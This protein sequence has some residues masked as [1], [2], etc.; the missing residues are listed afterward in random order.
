MRRFAVATVATAI[1]LTL[2][3][4]PAWVA[5]ADDGDSTS[6]TIPSRA[7][8]RAA[9]DAASDKAAE[10]A[11]VQAQLAVANDSLR[12]SAIRAA[13]AE[14]AFNRARWNYREARKAA[15]AAERSLR[16]AAADLVDMRD[17]Y[18]DTVASSYEMSPSLTTLSAIL[19][20]DGISTV[21][22]RTSSFQNAQ[23]VLDQVYDDYSAAATLAGVASDQAA[24]ARSAAAD[25]AEQ[26]RPGP[27][28][29]PRR[30]GARSR[31]GAGHRR[32]EG[33]P[34]RAARPPPGHQRRARRG[35]AGRARGGGHPDPDART[36]TRADADQPA[37][38]RADP[39]ADEAADTHGDAHRDADHDA[40][41]PADADRDAHPHTPPRR[42]PRRRPSRL[43][44]RPR[45]PPPPP[46]S[47]TPAAPPPPAG[48]ASAAIAFAQAQIGE[49]YQW[50][51]AGPDRWDCSG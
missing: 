35:A 22:D 50:G 21:I 25:L 7:D 48:G 32:P 26:T 34:D 46:P 24:E 33:R 29:R 3:A 30:P 15:R 41:G 42:R 10:V 47:A 5:T 49:P 27:R 4:G 18:A 17:A 2:A 20:A 39:G 38:E 6:D 37:D 31:R 36:H 19:Q 1:T 51:A 8:V 23:S 40:D 45:P 12:R 14:E 13:Q 11:G 16:F 44:R 43:P 9:Q 28:G